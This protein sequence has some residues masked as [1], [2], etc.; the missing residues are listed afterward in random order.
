M[1]NYC[2]CTKYEDC[3]HDM[4]HNYSTINNSFVLYQ[5]N[6]NSSEKIYSTFYSS[7]YKD[8]TIHPVADFRGCKDK[9]DSLMAS[10][11]GLATTNSYKPLKP[12][13]YKIVFQISIG[14]NKQS[15]SP[16]IIE[17]TFDIIRKQQ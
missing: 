14:T 12:G 5:L 16:T 11:V 1:N 10:I 8:S 3:E 15:N 7:F 6:P 4:V 2:L 13:K 9:R 17:K